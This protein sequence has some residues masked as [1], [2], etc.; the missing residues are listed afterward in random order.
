MPRL[1]RS[2]D[3][4]LAALA[5]VLALA[6]LGQ[7]GIWDPD[8]GRYTNVALHMLDSGNWLEPHRSEEVGHWTKP[9][10]TYWAIAASVATF[11]RNPW[12]ARLPAAL[13]YLLCTWLVW[14]LARRLAPGSERQAAAIFATMLLP[15]GAAQ[16]ITT[17]YLLAAC[18]ALALY[19]FVEARFG[20]P[21][22]ARRWL[23]LLWA[24]FALA[25]L[26]KGP[27][28]LL[29]LLAVAAFEL[30][31][32]ATD[33][34]G[35]R[36]ARVLQWWGPLLF[37]AIALPWYLAVVL[38][39]PGLLDYFLGAEVVD[40]IASNHFN[41]HGQWYGWLAIYAPTL[42]LGT[43]PWTPA[44]WRWA[45][46]L[47]AR[48]RTWR[49]RAGRADDRAGLL[50]ALWLLLPLLVFC[51]SRSRLPLYLLPLFV[52]LALLAAR[53]R[54]GEGR[55]LPRWRWLLA[56]AALLL[57]L[58]LATALWPTHKD[59][60][61]WQ[62][63]IAARAPGRVSQINIVDDMA[64]YGLYLQLGVDVEKLSLRPLAQPRFNPEY[65]EDLADELADDYDPHALWFTKQGNYPAVR[66]RLQALGY[67]ALPQGT[68]YQG[69]VLFRVRRLEHRDVP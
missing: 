21:Q 27:P 37:A 3:V 10:L 60:A 43:L 64:R 2:P 55:G 66:A 11:G 8:E 5:L 9:P 42:L 41:R 69:R 54:Q 58:E 59:G 57:A 7:R 45:R 32:P 29:P 20:A 40:R 1:L 39:N 24:G 25:F 49:T 67:D 51:V 63:A 33:A 35:Q 34:S 61:A 14:R 12:A 19:G 13:S 26:T 65:D 47:P 46:A 48:L 16:L 38:R 17:D 44:L 53:Q 56:W 50:L 52:P 30:L 15:F 31:T 18:E 22:Q 23:A 62:A 6:L 68:P 36:R 4:W 28:G